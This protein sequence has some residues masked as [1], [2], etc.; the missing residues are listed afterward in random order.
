VFSE[1]I[2]KYELIVATLCSFVNKVKASMKMGSGANEVYKLNLSAKKYSKHA[3]ML[4][5]YILILFSK[6]NY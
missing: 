4:Y 6:C 5:F 1:G 3:G 2:K